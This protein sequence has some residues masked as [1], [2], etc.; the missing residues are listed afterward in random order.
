MTN[1]EAMLKLV[2][3]AQAV[4]LIMPVGQVDVVPG[5]GGVLSAPL[6]WWQ[7]VRGMRGV[8]GRRGRQRR[9]R[10][11][12]SAVRGRRRGERL[13]AGEVLRAHRRS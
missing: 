4:Y 6:L 5:Y 11:G 12:R 3:L 1:L 13:R 2:N 7:G 10:R 9:V 8:R